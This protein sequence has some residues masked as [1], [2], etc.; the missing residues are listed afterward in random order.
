MVDNFILSLSKYFIYYYILFY[1]PYSG[2]GQLIIYYSST[3]KSKGIL[4]TI[5][6]DEGK[7]QL[8]TFKKLQPAIVWN[9]MCEKLQLTIY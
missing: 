5:I 8:F 6:D 7:Q 2:P 4:C 3:Q 1:H 9:F